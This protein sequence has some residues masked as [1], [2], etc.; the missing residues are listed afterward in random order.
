[1]DN[2]WDTGL[3]FVSSCGKVNNDFSIFL[4]QYVISKI[5]ILMDKK[6]E[7]EWLCY[8]VGEISWENNEAVVTD[9]YIPSSQTVTKSKIDKIDCDDQTRQNIIGVIHS[10]N[11]MG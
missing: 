3:E 7:I 6:P 5:D 8:L 11:K 1:M 10:H 9:L 2:E 4:D